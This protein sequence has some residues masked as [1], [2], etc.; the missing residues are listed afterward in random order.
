MTS[1]LISKQLELLKEMIPAL[2]RVAVLW[3]P[4]NPGNAP[5]L[6]EAEVAAR[7]LGVRLQ[8]LEVRN[9]SD[10]DGAFAAMTKERAG[11]LLVLV[12]TMLVLHRAR[13]ADLATQSRLPAVY[14]L[15]DHVE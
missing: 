12:D 3:N 13:V 11:A 8:R 4:A 15:M 10:L 7:T 2:S 1:E 5:Q 6:R 14:G 9:P